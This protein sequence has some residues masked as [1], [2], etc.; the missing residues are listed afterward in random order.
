MVSHAASTAT[1]T[2][3]DPV[4]LGGLSCPNRIIMA[5]LTRGRATLQGVPTPR[6]GQ[7]YAQRANAGLIITEATAISPQGYGWLN[8]PGLFTDE[9][10]ASWQPVVHAIHQAGGRVVCQLWHMGR[11]SHPDFYGITPVAPSA[12]KPDGHA[13]TPKGDNPFVTPHALTTDEIAHV[14]ADYVAAAHRAKA[15]GFDGVELHAANG[16][17]LDE[18][19][20]TSTNHRTDAYGGS[21]TNRCRLIIEVLTA[22][23]TVWPANRVG[24]RVSPATPKWGMADTNPIETFGTLAELLNPLGLAYLHSMEALPGHMLAPAEPTEPVTP[25]MRKAFKGAVI[26]C[27]GYDTTTANH[28]LAHGQADAVAFGVPFIANP[29][30]VYRL[31]TNAPLNTPDPVTFYTHGDNGYLDYPT[32]A[33]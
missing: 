18:F 16:Y 13:H 21:A 14:V 32:S 2:L 23:C 24:L 25:T 3:F 28:A 33:A 19:L 7:Y 17:L 5:P 27:G 26:V 4:M 12:L 9:Q 11:V 29:D 22:L 15:A 6:M 1:H 10:Q 8:A 30:L 31:Q 20:R